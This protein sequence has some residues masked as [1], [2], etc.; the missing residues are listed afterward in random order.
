MY[1]EGYIIAILEVNKTRSLFDFTIAI[2]SIDQLYSYI[3]KF[4]INRSIKNNDIPPLT[5]LIKDFRN[6]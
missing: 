3:I 4:D 6:Y 1:S 2:L 5:D